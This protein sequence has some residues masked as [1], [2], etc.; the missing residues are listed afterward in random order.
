MSNKEVHAFKRRECITTLSVA[1]VLRSEFNPH[2]GGDIRKNPIAGDPRTAYRE[3]YPALHDISLK[4]L[5]GMVTRGMLSRGHAVIKRGP[6]IEDTD[7]A[8]RRNVCQ[9]WYREG[10]GAFEGIRLELEVGMSR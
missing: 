1:W 10:R 5:K 3:Y 2:L 8:R 4:E 6:W 9:F 7:E